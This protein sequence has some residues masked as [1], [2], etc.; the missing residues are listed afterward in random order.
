MLLDWKGF[1][2]RDEE[3]RFQVL[4]LYAAS[5]AHCQLTEPKGTYMEFAPPGV[6]IRYMVAE[7]FRV[8]SLNCVESKPVEGLSFVGLVVA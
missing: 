5:P 7:K 4:P 8:S 1:A 3:F 2:L 6:H